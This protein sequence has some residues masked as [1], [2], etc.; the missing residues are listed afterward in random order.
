MPPEAHNRRSEMQT[1]ISIFFSLPQLPLLFVLLQIV[2]WFLSIGCIDLSDG[3]ECDFQVNMFA[4]FLS[5][6]HS[7]TFRFVVTAVIANRP[8]NGSVLCQI[9]SYLLDSIRSRNRLPFE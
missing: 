4:F 9:V 8:R 2:F 7:R 3:I 5:H 1:K 6:T